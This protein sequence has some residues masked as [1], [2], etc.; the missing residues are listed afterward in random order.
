MNECDH[1]RLYRCMSRWVWYV[2]MCLWSRLQE[3]R[4]HTSTRMAAVDDAGL[5]GDG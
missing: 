3:G 5:H 2:G 4:E 1:Q